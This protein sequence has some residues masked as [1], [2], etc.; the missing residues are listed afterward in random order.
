MT[1]T[2]GTATRIG[3]IGNPMTKKEILKRRN[4]II[5]KKNSKIETQR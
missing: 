5:K 4:E 1:T 3:N 2:R